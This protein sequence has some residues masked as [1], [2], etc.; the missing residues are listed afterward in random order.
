MVVGRTHAW[1]DDGFDDRVPF[2]AR[3]EK[4]DRIAL[5]AIGR[6]LRYRARNV[7]LR[8][9][10][11]SAH[12]LLI[13]HGWTKVTAIAANGYEALLA[14][15]GPG[16]IV[17]EGAALSRRQRSATVTALEPVEAV[18]IEQSRFTAF[19]G[20]HPPVALHL[21][22]LATDRQRST[23]R[24][25][26]EWA[27][28]TV[29]E[30]LAVLLLELVRTHGHRTDEGIELTIGLSQQEFAGSVGSSREAV[31][32]LLRELRTRKVVTTERRRIVVLRP[33]VLRRIVGG[34][35][36]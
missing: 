34:H 4:A 32:R 33:D 7:I 28:L 11:P 9:D 35:I 13:L 19:L 22:G 10:E 36:V 16:D 6:P 24:R 1:D 3:L 14:L 17:G 18:V 25:R 2:L 30:R 20:D 5:L 23:D 15:R 29:R 31:A 21:L 27:A 8:Q 12:V 26:L